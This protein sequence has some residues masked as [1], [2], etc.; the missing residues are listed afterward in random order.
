MQGKTE[1]AMRRARTGLLCAAMALVCADAFAE[2][3]SFNYMLHCQGCHLAGGTETPGKIPALIGAG[4]FLF[5][6]GG[7]EFLV[8]VPGVSLSTIDD[9]ELAELVNWVLRRFSPDEL[10]VDF[11]PYT[12]NE[13][14][15]LRQRPL[16][17]VERTRAKLTATLERDTG[18]NPGGR[19]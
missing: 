5:V 17:E 7:R 1:S 9:E 16:V 10:P 19:H 4:R 15:R 6:E 2:S 12:K 11:E 13:V 3:P 14:A 8:Q 18:H